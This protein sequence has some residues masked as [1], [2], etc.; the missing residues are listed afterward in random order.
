MHVSQICLITRASD[1]QLHSC[2]KSVL[3]ISAQ[4]SEI[5]QNHSAH[6]RLMT[7]TDFIKLISQFGL[8]YQKK[9]LQNPAASFFFYDSVPHNSFGIFFPFFL[10]LQSDHKLT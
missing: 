4:I 10:I 3:S 8:D 7:R 9:I 2:V 6:N 1:K 5:S